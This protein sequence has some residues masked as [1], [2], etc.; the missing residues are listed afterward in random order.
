MYVNC[1]CYLPSWFVLLHRL[2]LSLMLADISL[3]PLEVAV[4]L[5]TIECTI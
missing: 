4:T 5:K 2:K 3:K 1:F